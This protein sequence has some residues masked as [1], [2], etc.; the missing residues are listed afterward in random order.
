MDTGY[1]FR[2][3][4]EQ[5]MGHRRMADRVLI[6]G[7]KMEL[8]RSSIAVVLL[9]ILL[10]ISTSVLAQVDGTDSPQNK[11]TANK[12]DKN[13]KSI[14]HVNPSTLAME[15]NLPLM[16]YPGRNGNGLPVG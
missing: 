3:I 14:A 7:D 12:A 9:T 15:M 1:W 6:N 13:L 8:T 10:F 2:Q 4:N 11:E 5:N 16:S